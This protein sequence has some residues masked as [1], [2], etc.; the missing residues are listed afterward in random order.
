LAEQHLTPHARALRHREQS[1]VLTPPLGGTN[2]RRLGLV[3]EC[4]LPDTTSPRH[5]RGLKRDADL[6]FQDRQVVELAEIVLELFEPLH[7]IGTAIEHRR[8][9]LQHVP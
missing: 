9:R 6:L 8:E 7:Q 3:I 2:G 1:R 4:Q 5:R